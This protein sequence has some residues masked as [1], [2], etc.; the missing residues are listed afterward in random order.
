MASIELSEEA[1][2]A[3]KSL[4]YAHAQTFRSIEQLLAT[5]GKISSTWFDILWVLRRTPDRRLRFRDLER[6]VPLSRS[7]LSRSIDA[8]VRAGFVTKQ[9]CPDDQRGIIV[10]LTESGNRALA[11]AWPVYADGIARFFAASLSREDCARLA[12]IL[13]RIQPPDASRSSPSP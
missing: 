6:E 5:R 4:L 7:A 9:P 11:A 12:E 3:W 10:S 2:L 8:L 1:L 13:R